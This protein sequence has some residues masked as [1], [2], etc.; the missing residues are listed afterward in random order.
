M[1]KY[2]LLYTSEKQEDNICLKNMFKSNK[3]IKAGF[4]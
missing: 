1:K 3:E 2:I 4:A